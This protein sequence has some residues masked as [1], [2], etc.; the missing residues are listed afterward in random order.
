MSKSNSDQSGCGVIII[1]V[2]I[3]IVAF[4][5]NKN[6]KKEDII[7]PPYTYSYDTTSIKRDSY[8]IVEKT[9]NKPAKKL[10]NKRSSSTSNNYESK[11]VTSA[12]Q[13]TPSV[14]RNSYVPRSYSSSQCLGTTKKGA[15]C[16]NI[17]RSGNGYCW[18][19]GG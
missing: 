6:N 12:K 19:H 7:T 10:K 4:V 14:R 5:K 15:R 11:Y 8:K 3:V 18:R 9:A 2:I 17:T 16:R 13:Y 1:L